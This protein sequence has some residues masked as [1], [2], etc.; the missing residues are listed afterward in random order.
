M[1]F[2]KY[3][4]YIEDL[5]NIWIYNSY[6]RRI[7]KTDLI[8]FE[9]IKKQIKVD[10]KLID[11]NIIQW[12]LDAGIICEDG[13]ME[14]EWLIKSYQNSKVQSSL[15][16]IIMASTSC[17]FNCQYCY[18]NLVPQIIDDNFSAV[19][20]EC[21]KKNISFFPGLFI[22]WFG[23]EPLLAGKK[24]IDLTKQIKEIAKKNHKPYLSSITTNGYLLDVDKF[25]QLVQGNVV[26]FQITIDGLKEWHD[27]YRPLKSGRGNIRCH[28]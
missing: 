3:N 21:L 8:M 25:I 9:K 15:E 20:L 27:K 14:S 23:G 7:I 12:L 11:S 1:V 6:T 19:F 13:T 4:Y 2:S 26:F 28:Y 17:N 5:K 18:E 10:V 24:I 22:E 16:F